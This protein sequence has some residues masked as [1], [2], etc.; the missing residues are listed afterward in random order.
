M[1]LE[2]MNSIH[3]MSLAALAV[4]GGITCA[5]AAETPP[6]SPTEFRITCAVCHGVNGKGD[7][8]LA[9]FL[10]VKPADLTVL[11][12]KNG[13]EYPFLRVFQTIDGRTQVKAHGDRTMPVWGDRYVAE[14]NSPPGTYGSELMVRARTLELVYYIQ[15]IQEK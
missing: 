9:E 11:A 13:G 1:P 6:I 8:I 10:K 15:S 5:V 3:S 7:G 12:K 14:A 2:P 4:A